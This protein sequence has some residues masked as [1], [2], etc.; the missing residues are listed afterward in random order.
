MAYA[1][2]SD[3]RPASSR[4]MGDLRL[5][6]VHEEELVRTS[7]RRGTAPRNGPCLQSRLCNSCCR[8]HSMFRGPER[9]A[10]AAPNPHR[11][12]VCGHCHGRD[13]RP[14]TLCGGNHGA[15]IVH[16]V[17]NGTIERTA[18]NGVVRYLAPAAVAR[19]HMPDVRTEDMKGDTQSYRRCCSCDQIHP[20]AADGFDEKAYVCPDC[21]KQGWNEEWPDSSIRRIMTFVASLP[22]SDPDC[23][24]M[25][26]LLL[27]AC[28]EDL[29][30]QQLTTMALHGT[31]WEEISLVLDPLLDAYRGRHRQMQLFGRIGYGTFSKNCAEAG[32]PDYPRRWGQVA[33]QRNHYAHSASEPYKALQNVCFLE[34]IR[35]TKALFA[36]LHNSYNTETTGYAAATDPPRPGELREL[37]EEL[38]EEECEPEVGQVSSE[39]APSAPPDEPST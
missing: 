14:R 4:C 12:M 18:N 38:E 26:C 20:V 10:A 5:F 31:I 3:A 6:M 7:G 32:F 21:G 33:D 1:V 30:R 16:H 22:P 28:L 2:R 35:E 39:A 27:S 34:F 25:S 15:S 36:H 23:E 9:S 11:W 13:C 8:G 17:S 37:I 29:M 24:R 19:K